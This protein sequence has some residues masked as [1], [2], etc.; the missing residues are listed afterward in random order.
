M[1]ETLPVNIAEGAGAKTFVQQE[2]NDAHAASF[3]FKLSIGKNILHPQSVNDKDGLSVSF[4]SF[5]PD[6]KTN[7][8]VAC[9]KAG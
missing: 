7:L 9:F 8:Q 6:F 2:S 3:R 4:T 5:V 1:E